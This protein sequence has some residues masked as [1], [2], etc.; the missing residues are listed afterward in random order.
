MSYDIVFHSEASKEIK[1]SFV[2]YELKQ[3]GLGIKFENE[4]I[5]TLDFIS[6]HPKSFK[7]QIL[8]FRETPL[9]K[10]PFVV[11]YKISE[12]EKAIRILAV[13]HA[14]RNPIKKFRI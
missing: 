3:K 10:F 9:K 4:L 5:K 12:Q 2:W 6:N 14:K 11:V 8:N 1:E 7:I 13:Y